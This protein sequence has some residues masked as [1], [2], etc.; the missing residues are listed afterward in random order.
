MPPEPPIGFEQCKKCELPL[1]PDAK[2]CPACGYQ[3]RALPS[4]GKR[5]L[6]T[7]LEVG[8]VGLLVVFVAKTLLGVFIFFAIV[9]I[10]LRLIFR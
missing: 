2:E 8:V 7:S 4:L 9:Y 10:I 5:A 1:A 3:P 6:R